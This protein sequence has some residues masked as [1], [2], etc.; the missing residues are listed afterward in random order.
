KIFLAA[1]RLP[2]AER[3]EFIE[4][5][6]VDDAALEANVRTLVAAHEA[7]GPFMVSPTGTP[8]SPMP[9]PSEPTVV[10]G[11]R[12]G[13]YHIR[14]IIAMGGM[15]IVYEAVQEHPHRTVALKVMRVGVTSKSAMRRFEY[16]VQTLA[17]LPHANIAQIY[18]AGT[19]TDPSAP[20]QSVPYFAM[21]YVPNA[22]PLIE[23][24]N[25]KKLG[26]RE[27][28]AL[29]TKIC[30]AVDHANQRGIIHRDLKPSNVLVDSNGEPKIIDFG[31]AR[32][33]DSDLAMTTMQT[34]VGQ[35]IGT[36]QYMSPEQC[37]ADPHAL[38]TRSD[39][40]SLGV[41]LYE[42]L[43]DQLPYDVQR[44]ALH[45][46]ARVIREQLPARPSSVNRLLR[47][48]V[49]T[50]TL[51]A[52]EKDRTRRYQT[53]GQFGE[54]IQHYLKDEPILAR[55]PSM[56]RQIERIA[57]N[58]RRGLA[59][60]AFAVAA[61]AVGVM[62]ARQGLRQDATLVV[63]AKVV[64]GGAATMEPYTGALVLLRKVNIQT[65]QLHPARRLGRTPLSDV[66]IA[67]GYYRIIV[68]AGPEG[69]A[70]QIQYLHPSEKYEVS[71]VLR[72]TAEVVVGMVSITAGPATVGM[73]PADGFTGFKVRKVTLDAF[74]IDRTEVTNAQYQVFLTATGHPQPAFWGD[75]WRPRWANLPVVG[76]EWFDAQA[77]AAWAGKRLPTDLEWERAARGTDRR[78]YPWGAE[79]NPELA[80]VN[81]VEH[82]TPK[83]DPEVARATYEA[84]VLPADRLPEGNRDISPS[85]LLHVLGNVAEWTESIPYTTDRTGLNPMLGW[86]IIKGDNWINEIGEML[87]LA[88]FRMHP[89]HVKGTAYGFRCAKSA[90]SQ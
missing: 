15:G 79:E 88:D 82:G 41:L 60:A 57:H 34:N 54:D 1:I 4:R 13:N 78:P 17:R 84:F 45:E 10:E 69:F 90:N 64:S 56:L 40:Y 80:N 14:R 63:T 5:A 44:V 16:E 18:E 23:Y 35:L 58:H 19:H 53:A 86:R 29:F 7:A 46:A 74:W 38:D 32:A 28:L 66:S 42:L 37:E 76:V 21:E 2:V 26:V 30:D 75:T 25:V 73:S 22:R 71:V 24:A 87:N 39:V 48:D 49:E 67:P 36:L 52:L 70:E 43:C 65:R 9:H 27:R 3:R 55:P 77:Y 20:S 47:G 85:G 61:L 68:D 31:V 59:A 89:M 62:V 8:T 11:T 12:I 83:E 81:R 33:T 50:I 72:P 6:C 51:K